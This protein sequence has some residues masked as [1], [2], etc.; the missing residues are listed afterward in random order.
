MA[1]VERGPDGRYPEH[2]ENT[3]RDWLEDIW[4]RL[5]ECEV[6]H[7][8][9]A[10]DRARREAASTLDRSVNSALNRVGMTVVGEVMQTVDFRGWR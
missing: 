2:R 3:S 7:D 9:V 5:C 6:T 10:L 1:F 4:R 8:P